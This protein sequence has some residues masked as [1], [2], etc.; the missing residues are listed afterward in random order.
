MHQVLTVNLLSQPKAFMYHRI[1]FFLLG[2]IACFVAVFMASAQKQLQDS[3]IYERSWNH[4][5]NLTIGST[6]HYG[7]AVDISNRAWIVNGSGIY[8]F[9]ADTGTAL[10]N[11][12]VANARAL[13]FD[14]VSNLFFVCSRQNTSPQI[15]LPSK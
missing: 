14:S 10:T 6:D 1:K 2:C 4:G 12:A 3:L 5:L 9:T 15:I 8:V 11:W 13:R 7:I